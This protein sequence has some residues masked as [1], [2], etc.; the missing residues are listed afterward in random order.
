MDKISRVFDFVVSLNFTFGMYPVSQLKVL[1]R[2][3]KILKKIFSS[4]KLSLQYS[5][6]TGIVRASLQSSN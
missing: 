3:N 2:V 1:G 4:L 6:I 5:C